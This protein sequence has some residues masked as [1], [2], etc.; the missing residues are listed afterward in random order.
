MSEQ[1]RQT[2]AP[3]PAISFGILISGATVINM[4]GEVGNLFK[5]DIL[6]DNGT[7]TPMGLSLD[8]KGAQV[9]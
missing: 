4:N 3:L 6:I 5:G 7:I 1:H 9:S 2:L 8:A